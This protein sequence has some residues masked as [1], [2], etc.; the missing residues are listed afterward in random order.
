MKI[1]EANYREVDLK[2]YKKRR[3]TEDDCSQLIDYDCLITVDGVPKI[4]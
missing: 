2:H 3:A 4:L 1:I